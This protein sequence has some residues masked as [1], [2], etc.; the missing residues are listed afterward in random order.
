MRVDWDKD[1]L[2]WFKNKDKKADNVV[3]FPTPK[4]VPPMP[5]V[6]D[7]EEVERKRKEEEKDQNPVYQIGKTATGRV[8]F[9][10]G[11][12]YQFTTITMNNTGVDTLIR[13]LQAAK[14]PDYDDGEEDATEDEH[15]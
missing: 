1:M 14:E 15:Q 3:D 12:A 13:M 4:A 6:E 10:L 8:S 2:D 5:K 7:P 11:N 9:R